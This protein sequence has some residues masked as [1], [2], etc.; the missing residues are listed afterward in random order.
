MRSYKLAIFTIFCAFLY[1]DI[2][3]Q[4]TWMTSGRIHS[5]FDWYTIRTDNFNIHYHEEIESIAL[6]GA[7]IAEQIL[8]T[9]LEQVQLETIPKIDIILTTED[10]VM[11]GFA[12]YF[13]STFIWVD[14]NDAAVWLENQKWLEQVIAHE[15]QHIVFFNK[16][17]TWLL[18]PYSLGYG[19]TPG[20]FIEGIAEYYTE[21]WRPYRSEL[22]HKYNILKIQH[23]Q[24]TLIMMDF[25]K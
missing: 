10:E 4:L 12:F 25:Q 3:H 2:N 1:S 21:E 22:R 8:P 20:W 17:K 7:N 9:L 15:L 24:W 23:H 16:I 6:S 19:E 14:Q 11:N 5:D 18:E 13:N